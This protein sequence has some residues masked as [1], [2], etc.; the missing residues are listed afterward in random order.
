[1]P[2]IAAE[3]LSGIG[4]EGYVLHVGKEVISLAARDWRQA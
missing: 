4:P 3:E 1:M 2:G